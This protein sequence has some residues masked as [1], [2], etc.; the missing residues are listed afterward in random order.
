MA[1]LSTDSARLFVDT[2]SSAHEHGWL[3][4]SRHPTSEGTLR[5]VRC[6]ACGIRR[7]DVQPAGAVTASALTRDIGQPISPG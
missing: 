3:T 4:E 6:G 2:A 1:P 7:V 5:Y